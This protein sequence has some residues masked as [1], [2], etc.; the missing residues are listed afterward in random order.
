VFGV[1]GWAIAAKVVDYEEVCVDDNQTITDERGRGQHRKLGLVER[2]IKGGRVVKKVEKDEPEIGD[3]IDTKIDWVSGLGVDFGVHGT[4]EVVFHFWG[5]RA[6]R[7]AERTGFSGRD[8]V[9][10]RKFLNLEGFG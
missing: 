1:A 9:E 3:D 7:V 6:F 2:L 8:I 4:Y 5:W 10:S